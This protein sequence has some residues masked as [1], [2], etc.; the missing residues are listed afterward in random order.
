MSIVK[1]IQDG[2]M[3]KQEHTQLDDT[4][5]GNDGGEYRVIFEVC[6]ERPGDLILAADDTS[7]VNTAVIVGI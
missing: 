6:P 2:S 1:L 4:V 5:T 7:S 3:G